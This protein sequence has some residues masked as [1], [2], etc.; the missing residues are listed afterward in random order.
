MLGSTPEEGG[1]FRL[2]ESYLYRPASEGAGTSADANGDLPNGEHWAGFLGRANG[3]SGKAPAASSESFVNAQCADATGTSSGGDWSSLS[4]QA[5]RGSSSNGEE[6]P[7]VSKQKSVGNSE[8]GLLGATGV[9]AGPLS[10]M[11]SF[12]MN[13][14]SSSKKWGPTVF[15]GGQGPTLKDGEEEQTSGG[16]RRHEG[17]SY[18]G[19]SAS[20]G[21]LGHEATSL[22]GQEG[23]QQWWY[24][25]SSQGEGEG[26]EGDWRGP[27]GRVA[28]AGG[29][30]RGEGGGADETGEERQGAEGGDTLPKSFE[31]QMELALALSLQDERQRLAGSGETICWT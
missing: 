6:L 5:A 23:G 31:D 12:L 11:E 28:E 21:I 25:G 30:Q 19:A 13:G 20:A 14:G 29:A 17:T 18:G 3:V 26:D 7:W 24:E 16:A 15:E 8:G 10:T 4:C 22:R 2:G 1:A 27:N 9:G